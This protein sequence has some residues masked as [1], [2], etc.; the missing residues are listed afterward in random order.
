MVGNYICD[1]TLYT[2]NANYLS[3][4][5]TLSAHLPETVH[6]EGS[7]LTKK[8]E[9]HVSLMCV[10]ELRKEHPAVV[11][12]VVPDFCAFT[13]KNPVA[14]VGFTGEF[15]FAEEGEKKTLVAPC[16][17]SNLET[18]SKMFGNLYDVQIP[19]QP[20]HVTLYTLQPNVGIGLNSQEE[21]AHKSRSII[22]PP[23]VRIIKA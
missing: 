2:Y 22:P 4:P 14:F 11:E 8:D 23:E 9:F 19:L 1:G 10:R 15:R 13:A 20:T 12:K 21:M 5:I 18:F 16:K 17:V 3:L 6:I 7:L